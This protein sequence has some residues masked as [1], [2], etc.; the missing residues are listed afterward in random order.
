MDILTS[1]ATTTRKFTIELQELKDKWKSLRKGIR[2]KIAETA[3]LQARLMLSEKDDIGNPAQLCEELS[4]LRF[5]YTEIIVQE[6]EEQDKIM[7]TYTHQILGNIG[8]IPSN[9]GDAI[10][11]RVYD[12][13]IQNSMEGTKLLLERDRDCGIPNPKGG[14]TC[15]VGA[16]SQPMR[17]CR[18][19]Q[20]NTMKTIINKKIAEEQAK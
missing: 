6:K 15:P 14:G 16:G 8:N 1:N 11:L 12:K 13:Y 2:D 9:S 17:E 4:K 7:Q 18:G 19:W 5:E 20:F 10:K 3:T